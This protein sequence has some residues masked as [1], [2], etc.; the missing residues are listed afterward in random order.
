MSFTDT[1]G[2]TSEENQ[3]DIVIYQTE[4]GETKIDVRFVD[5]TVWLSLDQLSVL[6]ERNKSTI[7]RHLKNI[8]EEGELV[9]GAVVANFATTAADGKNYQVD[10]YISRCHYF[11][12][13][14]RKIAVWY[15]VPSVGNKAAQ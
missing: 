11:R 4:D 9:R 6:F 5:E 3:G 10:Y 1:K 13:L 7:S 15:T 12:R 8:F 14:S 2:F